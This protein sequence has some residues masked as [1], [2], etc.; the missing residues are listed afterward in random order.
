MSLPIGHRV[1]SRWRLWRQWQ[2]MRLERWWNERRGLGFN[3]VD[4]DHRGYFEVRP[5]TCPYP[6]LFDWSVKACQ[7]KGFC[8]CNENNRVIDGAESK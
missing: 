5:G 6:V 1:V 7:K 2:R 8:G 4:D 3:W